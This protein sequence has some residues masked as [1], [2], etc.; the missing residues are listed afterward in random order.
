MYTAPLCGMNRSGTGSVEG[1]LDSFWDVC[2]V[3]SEVGSG[4]R[5]MHGKQT[6]FIPGFNRPV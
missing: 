6:W 3:G 2:I 4:R 5:T 1:A